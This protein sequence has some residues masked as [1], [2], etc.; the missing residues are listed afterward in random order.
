MKASQ[1]PEE[2]T[3]RRRKFVAFVYEWKCSN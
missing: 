2:E 3:Y 1:D